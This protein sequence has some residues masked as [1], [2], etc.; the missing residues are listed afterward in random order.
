N[1]W[2]LGTSAWFPQP[3]LNGQMYTWDATIRVKKPWIAFSCG[4]TVRRWED[5][6]YNAVETRSDVPIAFGVMLAGDY[7]IQ[8]ETRDGLTVE[9][10]TYGGK[11][12]FSKALLDMAFPIIKY[13]QA[14]LG[15]YPYKEF[16]ILEKNEWGYG[17]APASIMFITKE[18]FN[19][20]IDQFNQAVAVDVRHRFVHE[21][22]HQ[23]WGCV[24]KMPSSQEQWIT[25][26]FADACASLC[27]M[28]WPQGHAKS[29]YVKLIAHWK[30]EA[31]YATDKGTI[32]TC[33]YNYNPDDS[34][35]NFLVRTGLLYNKGAW[36][37]YCIRKEIGDEQFFRFLKS[38]QTNF[39]WK[40]GSTK[41][42]VGLLGFMTKKDWNPWFE[43][44]YWG[45]GMPEVKE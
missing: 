18:A 45:T 36:L 41:D 6:G 38:Y 35:E 20:T 24:V 4:D 13:Y 42:V 37:L 34:S 26:S 17:Q 27:L 25:E 21:I 9:V 39:K 14:F 7:S 30:S 31:G 22:A 40:F 15:P 33:N 12:Q 29:D 19:S 28:D 16:H 11:A 23:W 5:G 1:Y 3:D 44:N 2:Q 8:R 10:A 32:P 43:K